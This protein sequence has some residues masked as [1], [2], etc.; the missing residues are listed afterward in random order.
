MAQTVADLDADGLV[1]RHPDPDDKR[2]VR[3]ELTADGRAKLHELR[4]ARE[5]WLVAAMGAELDAEERRELIAVLPLL[6]RLAESS[7]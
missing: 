3:I 1:S 5:S 4:G 2:R 6:R 7:P